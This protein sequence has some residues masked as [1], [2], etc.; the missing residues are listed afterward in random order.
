MV[1]VYQLK[2]LPRVVRLKSKSRSWFTFSGCTGLSGSSANFLFI[3]I[4]F[5]VN[6]DTLELLSLLFFTTL[7]QI[8]VFL[9]LK[10]RL[11]F[12]KRSKTCNPFS[13]PTSLAVVGQAV[14]VTAVL[15]W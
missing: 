2:L 8:T 7:D 12:R 14:A 10:S 15:R 6:L 13:G 4:L 5:Y 3:L 1:V 9:M 11:R